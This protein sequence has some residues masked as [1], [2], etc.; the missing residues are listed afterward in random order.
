MNTKNISILGS[1]GSIGV[2]TLKVIDQFPHL[3]K[4]SGLAAGN[5]YEL[6]KNQIVK[7]KPDIASISN[8][9][10]A[11]KLKND[12]K[13]F[14][15]K[16]VFGDEGA[17]LVATLEKTDIVLSAISGAPGFVPTYEAIKKSKKIALA[18]KETM[19]M[20]GPIINDLCKK[21]NSTI[22][23]VDSEHSALFQV[24]NREPATSINN[25]IITAS[26]GPFLNWDVEK[27]NEVKVEDALKHPNWIMGKKITIDSATMMN[28]ALEIIEARWLFNLP[29]NKIKAVI[30]PQST[31]HGAVEFNDGSVIAHMGVSDMRIPIAYALSY[32]NRLNLNLKYPKIND[33]NNFNFEQIE[34]IRFPAVSLAYKALEIGK[35][36]SCVLNAAN[37]ITV[38]AFLEKKIKF[39]D[40]VKINIK[41]LEDYESN[42]KN[43][44][45]S[46]NNINHDNKDKSDFC[47]IIE[48]DRI[49][50]G[51]ALAFI[52]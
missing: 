18:N 33:Y 19:V 31:V 7:Y 10:H 46:V 51:K 25:I 39:T 38:L 24:L 35:L 52:R 14:K 1:T 40:I 5:N 11:E 2:N 42:Y 45:L 41:V 28:K 43:W 16:I 4:V 32:P 21:Y 36:A 12:F 13:N 9:Q 47:D 26:G 20:A 34:N 22:I 48:T 27:L 49:A 29:P 17:I 3:F 23:P 15:T 6:L 30:H 44:M 37:E 50:R 8:P